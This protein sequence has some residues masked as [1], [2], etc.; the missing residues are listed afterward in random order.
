[1]NLLKTNSKQYRSNVYSYLNG[2]ALDH[3]NENSEVDA[4]S[5]ISN[6]TAIGF[7]LATF[8]SEHN[9]LNN[10]K[11]MPNLQVRIADWIQGMPIGFVGSYYDMLELAKELHEVTELDAKQEDT[12]TSGFYSH[13]ACMIIFMAN[14]NHFN[15]NELY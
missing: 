12:I 9:F 15:L 13:M 1:M 4:Y 2:L 5:E 10:K 14:D 11:S 7:I 6:K 3:F 8:N